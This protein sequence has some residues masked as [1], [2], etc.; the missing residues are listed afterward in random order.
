MVDDKMQTIKRC[1]LPAVIITV[2]GSCKLVG[3]KY[4]LDSLV[5]VVS[6]LV[7]LARGYGE[8]SHL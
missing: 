2:H 1:E 6:M 4:S 5:G 3:R 8:N 7:F